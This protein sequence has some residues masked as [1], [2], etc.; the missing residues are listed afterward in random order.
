MMP[1]ASFVESVDFRRATESSSKYGMRQSTGNNGLSAD[2]YKSFWPEIGADLLAVI[3]ESLS[4]GRLPLSCRRAV[5]TL[6]TK[7]GDLSDIK[8]LEACLF[9]MQ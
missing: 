2:F 6:L 8:K 3:N 4:I 1:M 5:L 9:A 7:K